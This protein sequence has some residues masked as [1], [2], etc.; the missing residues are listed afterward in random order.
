MFVVQPVVSQYITHSPPVDSF[1][2]YGSCVLTIL[3][4]RLYDSPLGSDTVVVQNFRDGSLAV[5]WGTIKDL[6]PQFRWIIADSSNRFH[7]ELWLSHS[8]EPQPRKLA[9]DSVFNVFDGVFKLTLLA[10]DS[11]TVFDSASIMFLTVRTDVE[12]DP[13]VELSSRSSV[14][15]EQNY[16]N[17]FNAGTRILFTVFEPGDVSITAYDALGRNCQDIFR[18]NLSAG[19][20]T[21]NWMPHRLASG[22]Y[23]ILARQ[24]STARSIRCALVQ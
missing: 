15:L 19:T 12:E 1:T 8:L 4:F 11:L 13:P 23:I 18:G 5:G 2:V 16:P 21:F 24:G 9:L 22:S 7:Y 3:E 17:P 6:I 10:I 14:H 20:H